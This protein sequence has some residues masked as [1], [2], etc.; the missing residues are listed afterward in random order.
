MSYNNNWVRNL[1]ESYINNNRSTNLQEQLDEQ[2]ELNE[3][4]MNLIEALCEELGIDAEQLKILLEFDPRRG[5]DG[6]ATPLAHSLEDAQKKGLRGA[7]QKWHKR[8]A[9][10]SP[11][12]QHRLRSYQA[13]RDYVRN[14]GDFDPAAHRTGGKAARSPD[15][16]ADLDVQDVARF[17]RGH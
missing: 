17:K 8:L 5:E 9:S 13:G 16:R 7:K 3:Q 6:R 14:Q 2:V 12:G 4:L 15:V 1:S 11:A 10:L